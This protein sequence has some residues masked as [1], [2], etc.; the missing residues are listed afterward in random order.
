MK[1][2]KYSDIW[3]EHKRIFN[4][5]KPY[6]IN[7]KRNIFVIVAIKIICIPLGLLTPF[8][9]KI[10]ID[11]VMI[12]K[13]GALLPLVILGYIL[14]FALQSILAA[15]SLKNSN[16]ISNNYKYRLRSELWRV[17]IKKRCDYYESMNAAEV[18]R[19]IDN[20]PNDTANI[21]Q[22]HYIDYIFDLINVAVYIIAMFMINWQLAVIALSITPILIYL[23]LIIGS[24]TRKIDEHIRNIDN[25]YQS[26]QYD[27]FSK[28]REIKALNLEND[29]EITFEEY[30][31]KIGR[32]SHVRNDI[33]DF[34]RQEYW[35]LK[36]E[37]FIK[38]L[39]YVFGLIFILNG[40]LMIGSLL[41]FMNY[42]AN[43]V[44]LFESIDGKNVDF[45]QK[46]IN[47][48]R[49]KSLLSSNDLIHGV[50][51]FD[52]F[53]KMIEF[54][55]VVFSY[56]KEVGNAL[57]N[58]T[59]NIN[60]GEHVAIIGESG[61][62]KSTILKLLS[63]IHMP[64]SGHIK[65]DGISVSDY[66][67]VDFYK[68]VSIVM[69][70]NLLF[71]MTIKENLLLSNPNADDKMLREAC[72]KSKILDFIQTQ[73]NGFDTLIGERG[74]R[75]SGGQKQRIAIARTLLI[76]P[77]IVLFDE[78]TSAL[79][80]DTEKMLNIEINEIFSDKTM[81]IVAHRFSSIANANKI[82]VVKEGRIVGVGTH[83]ELKNSNPEYKRLFC[84]KSFA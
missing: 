10:L 19:I 59:F 7:N 84:E 83:S 41:M 65:I 30:R 9:Y 73:P 11:N 12:E 22:T 25:E 15:I 69:Q 54:D 35:V 23:G 72:A 77:D 6:F 46:Q 57:S 34:L 37:L 80:H 40:K 45:K 1:R 42:Y 47:L 43:G 81:I 17:L 14:T 44:S 63:G 32:Y 67:I 26:W 21:L 36:K 28:W 18:K 16:I 82:I 20:D 50:H 52:Q 49:M 2:E 27:I 79:D 75:L 55:N 68:L 60:K 78:A 71:N 64:D 51:R 48:S 70:D 66:N 33:Y 29:S 3:F 56:N 53:N 8:F 76:N 61:C 13:K 24:G 38:M 5:Y 62:G 74:I 31:R 58:V 4:E 39:L